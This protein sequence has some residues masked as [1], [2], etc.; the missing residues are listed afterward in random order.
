MVAAHA[1]DGD[2]AGAGDQPFLALGTLLDD[3]LGQAEVAHLIVPQLV[4]AGLGCE[5]QCEGA[6]AVDA[7]GFHRVHL[8]GDFEVA[9]HEGFSQCGAWD[10]A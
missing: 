8:N 6:V 5:H 4:A 1:L 9:G 10:L 3:A 2:G 7:D